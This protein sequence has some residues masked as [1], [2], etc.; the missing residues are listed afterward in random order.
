MSSYAYEAVN[1]TGVSSAGVIDVDSQ[2]EAVRRIR[3]MGLFPVRVAE[4]QQSR[5]K[6]AIAKTRTRRGQGLSIELFEPRVKSAAITVLTRQ[7]ATLVEAGLPML[8]GLKIL[9]QQEGNRRLKRILAE[10]AE[11]IEGG[12][13]LSEAL[14]QHPKIFNR[15]YINMVRAGEV[16]GALEITLKRL[17]EFMEKAQKI[18]GKVKSAMYYPCAVMFVATAIVGV[19]LVFVI[20]RF[21]TVFDGL[22]GGTPMPS[23]TTLILNLSEFAKNHF[24]LA[25]LSL[26][27]IGIGFAFTLK[28]ELG[29]LAFDQ[30]KL[31]SPVLGPLFRK[32]AIS[33][34]ARTL[35]TLL[36]SGVPVLQALTIARETSGNVVVAKLISTVHD[37]VKEGDNITTPLRAS[38]VFPPMVVGMVDIGEQTG[39]LPDMLMKIADGCDEEVDNTVSAMTSLLE[40]ILILFLAVVVGS[41]VIAMVWPLVILMNGNF[42]QPGSTDTDP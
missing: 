25:M 9:E 32:L 39:A 13:Q 42:G 41:I 12:S 7:M 34:F 35:G 30:F 22:L 20:P 24:V 3:E 27:A 6:R 14:A 21:K 16:G 26:L 40:P 17:A 28:T 4:R 19:M 37:G 5:I 15:L 18:K 11:S 36:G 23:F 10:V 2:R 33:R 1:A 8:R 29:R 38:N 31:K